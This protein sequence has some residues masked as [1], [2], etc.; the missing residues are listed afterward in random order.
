MPPWK[1]EVFIVAFALLLQSYTAMH[2]SAILQGFDFF[3]WTQFDYA[4]H[5]YW[6]QL[7]Y[8]L[9]SVVIKKMSHVYANLVNVCQLGN[10][11]ILSGRHVGGE[12]LPIIC[13]KLGVDDKTI[14]I[15]GQRGP[16]KLVLGDQD[17]MI[18]S[19]PTFKSVPTISSCHFWPS[20][21]LNALVYMFETTDC[22]NG[23]FRMEASNINNKH[24]QFL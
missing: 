14:I 15:L 18:L 23:Q 8:G 11:S 10:W 3:L 17:H 4:T 9:H 24:L 7:Y 12:I 19:K 13:H 22:Q 16:R 1:R 5:L 2:N 20:F 21:Q 6:S